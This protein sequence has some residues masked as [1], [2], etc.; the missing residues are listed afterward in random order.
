[1]GPVVFVCLKW[2]V[3]LYCQLFYFCQVRTV[4][5][6]GKPL[7]SN[8]KS[9][10]LPPEEI[11]HGLRRKDEPF[12]SSDELTTLNLFS[13]LQC[14]LVKNLS[15][16]I[17]TEF[18]ESWWSGGQQERLQRNAETEAIIPHQLLLEGKTEEARPPP[19]AKVNCRAEPGGMAP[20]R[21]DFVIFP[22]CPAGIP[23][24]LHPLL[25]SDE[26]PIRLMDPFF[27]CLPN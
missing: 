6:K 10:I 2:K 20:A 21:K 16:W 1:M 7:F 12:Q 17:H 3:V 18:L 25:L 5:G 23:F 4:G 14:G 15:P 19:W 24:F 8:H 11:G 9:G 26:L 27:C 22:Q 13:L